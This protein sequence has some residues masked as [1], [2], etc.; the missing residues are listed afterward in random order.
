MTTKL[1]LRAQRIVAIGELLYGERWQRRLADA[2]SVSPQL[3]NFVATGERAVTADL[4]GRVVEF[5]KAEIK[6]LGRTADSLDSI[7]REISREL[8]G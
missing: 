6:R 7:R 3:V 1:D 2:L 4:E 5:L 8:R